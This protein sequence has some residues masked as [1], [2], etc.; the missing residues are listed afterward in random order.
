MIILRITTKVGTKRLYDVKTT[1]K[2][3]YILELCCQCIGISVQESFYLSYDPKGMQ[4]MDETF[5]VKKC[6]LENGSNIYLQT[7]DFNLFNV[8]GQKK[9]TKE[10]NIVNQSIEDAYQKEGFRPGLQ[11]LKTIKNHWTLTDFKL[12]DAKFEFIVKSQKESSC[13]KINL[14][15]EMVNEFQTFM[16]RI[17]FQSYR[18]GF[19]YGSVKENQANVS[20]IYEPPQKNLDLL[21][22]LYADNV[23]KLVAALHLQRLGC[24]FCHPPRDANI[25]FEPSEILFLASIIEPHEVIVRVCQVESN[26]QMDSFQLSEQCFTMV[27]QGALDEE[28]KVQKPFTAIV[29]GKFAEQVDVNFFLVNVPIGHFD[30]SK[31]LYKFPKPHRSETIPTIQDVKMH[32]KD[33]YKRGWTRHDLCMDFHLLLFFMSIIGVEESLELVACLLEKNLHQGHEILLESLINS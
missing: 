20:L 17:G 23:E 10:G 29:E 2:I 18:V 8:G 30:D 31:F 22:D 12:L 15:K 13:S 32:F 5:S 6:K 19:L 1:W 28:C 7:G 33:S 4:H 21:E 11:S 9:I 26:I 3:S 25:L 27:E 14:N 16:Q 24:I